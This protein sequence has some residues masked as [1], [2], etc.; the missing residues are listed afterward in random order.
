VTTNVGASGSSVVTVAAL[1]GFSDTMTLTLSPVSGLTASLSRTTIPGSGLSTLTVSAAVPGDYTVTVKGTSGSISHSVTISVKVNPAPSTIL[2]LAPL[3]FYGI[4]GVLVVLV[5][6]GVV[7]AVRR[8]K[9][10]SV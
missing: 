5:A 7:L 6:A 10:Q 9:P 8:R 3:Q 1:N 2:G 4:A